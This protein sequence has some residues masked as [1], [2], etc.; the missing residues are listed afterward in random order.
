MVGQLCPDGQTPPQGLPRGP[1][2][3]AT[4]RVLSCKESLNPWLPTDA[5]GK[6]PH[7]QAQPSNS[8]CIP[9]YLRQEGCLQSSAGN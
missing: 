5:P 9:L 8:I 7:L 2:Q 6:G 3:S 4:T 1:Q